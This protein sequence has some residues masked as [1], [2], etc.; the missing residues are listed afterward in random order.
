MNERSNHSFLN[1][2]DAS[3]RWE[4]INENY[5]G[6]HSDHTNLKKNCPFAN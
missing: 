1:S 4:D 6:N 2:F 5:N 3:D